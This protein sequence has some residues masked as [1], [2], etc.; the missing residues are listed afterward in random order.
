MNKWIGIGRLTGDPLVTYTQAETP[1][2]IAK[3]NL[4]VDR[5]DKNKTTDFIS[6]VAFGKAGD[7][8]G[9]Y[10]NKGM[11]VAVSGRVQT[12]SYTDKDGRKVYTTD[13]AIESQEFC[14]PKKDTAPVTAPTDADGFMN[15]P[16]NIDEELPFN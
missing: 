11:K 12:G 9:K 5:G 2:T 10:F 7:F 13:I 8:A 14:E 16:D 4:A 15:I 6:C 1:L 3:Y